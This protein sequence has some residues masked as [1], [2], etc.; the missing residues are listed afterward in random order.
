[1]N[2]TPHKLQYL[3]GVRGLAAL[4]VVIAHLKI[5][6]AID[7]ETQSLAWLV[8][9][10]HSIFLGKLLNAF[11]DILFD[12]KFSVQVFW[13]LSGYVI[14]IKL[15][16]GTGNEYLFNAVI[17]RYFRLAIPVLG[18]V[19][20]GYGLLKAGFIY[21]HQ[22]V[23]VM[24]PK[25]L[26]WTEFYNFQPNLVIAL[27]SAVWDT[28]FNFNLKASYNPVL[29]TMSP[30]LYGSFFCFLLFAIFRKGR[31]RYFFYTGLAIL[32]VVFAYYWLT[33]FILGFF[34]CDIDHTENVFKKMIS[35]LEENILSKWYYSIGI[36]LLLVLLNGF[37]QDFY[38]AY[39]KIFTSAT[40]IFT[41]MH[42][43]MLRDFFQQKLWV[44]LG[45]LSFGLYLV[46]MPIIF[47]LS[48]YLMVHLGFS[49]LVSATIS[50]LLSMIVILLVAVLFTRFVDRPAINISNRMA[51]SILQFR[52]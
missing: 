31:G 27:R 24:G 52:R 17:K 3:E 26:S 29:W 25:Y 7:L 35:F 40:G 48:L 28:F 49:H 42:S 8:N 9:S 39:S 38:S 46:H 14:S 5:L 2:K 43:K 32:S 6:F 22:L 12:G 50:A 1:M 34:L 15:F 21:N 20:L 4:V 41:I 19:L 16:T 37:T 10:T 30:E 33:T 23:E 51:K 18:A 44:W 13:F 36:L 47:S 11:I 45:K